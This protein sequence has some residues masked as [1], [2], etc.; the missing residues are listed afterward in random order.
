VVVVVVM[1][2]ALES[3]AGVL[4]LPFA[5]NA[6]AGRL[7]G[8]RR[9]TAGR[10]AGSSR[11]SVALAGPGSVTMELPDARKESSWRSP[12]VCT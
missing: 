2:P 9:T 5:A 12:M 7:C 1:M 11:A 8:A 3:G 4:V 10:V 6:A